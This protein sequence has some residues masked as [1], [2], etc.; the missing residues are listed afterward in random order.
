MTAVP[1]NVRRAPTSWP[2]RAT[3]LP[4]LVIVGCQ[5]PAGGSPPAPTVSPA[6]AA[7]GAECA[8]IDLRT[9]RGAPIDL[10]GTWTSGTPEVG[11]QILYEIRQ[12]GDCLW[13]RGYSAFEGQ[14][15]GQSFEMMLSGTVHSDFTA[16]VALLE[17]NVGN[18]QFYQHFGRAGITLHMRFD[19]I[20]GEEAVTLEITDLR[21][22]AHEGGA[23]FGGESLFAT[24]G[25][26]IGDF[27]TR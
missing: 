9:P 25:P 18:P 22:R 7:G 2:V 19:D 15:P 14:E 21:A 23:G 8:S 1:L 11:N 16:N 27:L 5:V 20:D 4:I 17:L 24:G 26:A 10:N 13:G 3:L 6:A 12:S